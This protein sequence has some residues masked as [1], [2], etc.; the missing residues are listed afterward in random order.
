[1]LRRAGL[2]GSDNQGDEMMR[3]KGGGQHFHFRSSVKLLYHLASALQCKRH[4]LLGPDYPGGG[5]CL[6]HQLLVAPCALPFLTAV[7]MMPNHAG[8]PCSCLRASCLTSCFSY[9]EFVVTCPSMGRVYH[10]VLKTWTRA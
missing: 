10:S 4:P 2:R 1:M 5:S 9:L 8:I 6:Y 7:C 3:D